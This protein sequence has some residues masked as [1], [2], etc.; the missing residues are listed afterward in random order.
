MNDVINL[1][2]CPACEVNFI[3]ESHEFVCAECIP[4]VT[5]DLAVYEVHKSVTE[6][7][8][9][10]ANLLAEH[11]PVLEEAYNHLGEIINNARKNNE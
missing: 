6:V 9:H 1:I 8:R 7:D 4:Q 2:K 10:P 11:L 5:A 3:D